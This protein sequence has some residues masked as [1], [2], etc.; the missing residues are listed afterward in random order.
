MALVPEAARVLR[1]ERVLLRP[2]HSRR[3][4]RPLAELHLTWRR[5]ATNPALSAFRDALV[6]AFAAPAKPQD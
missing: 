5:D 4:P 1:F 3:G 2:L 6:K